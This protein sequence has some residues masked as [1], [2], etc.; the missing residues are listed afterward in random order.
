MANPIV[1]TYSSLAQQYDDE[2]NVNSCWGRG[3]EG[4]LSSIHMQPAYRMVLDVGCGTGRALVRLASESSGDVTFTGIDPAENMRK[5]AEER[6]AKFPN[7]R[8]LDGSFESI[9][10]EPASVDYLFS[11]FAFHWTT[12]LDLSVS[13]IA[14][15]LKP[16]GD[17]DLFFIGRQ[18]GREFIE[19]TSPIFL[20]YLGPRR[21]LDS[22]RLRKQLTRDAA[23]QLFSKSFDSKRLS[24]EESFTTY[25]DT[26][27]GHLG[28]WVRIEGH[29]IQMSAE[30]KKSCDREV[31]SALNALEG[32]NGIPYT[33]HQLHVKL[34]NP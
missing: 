10:L 31:K 30:E 34:R 21:L 25:Y 32:R 28:W 18:N 4:A 1:E 2:L 15:V 17:M 19:K 29:F 33:I 23:L 14:R 12:D 16:E 7:V 5:R 22:A 8:I 6:T 20:K 27:E 3:A 26:L 24:I 13:E 9:P 11:I